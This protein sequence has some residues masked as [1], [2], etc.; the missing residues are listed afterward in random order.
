M[1]M[2]LA[3]QIVRYVDDHQPGWVE[4]QFVDAKGQCHTFRDKVPGFTAE[5]LGPESAYP[6]PGQVRCEALSQSQD[7]LE[8]TLIHISTARP[9]DIESTEGLSEFEV[10]S[11][12]LSA[13]P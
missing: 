1:K 10:L 13:I 5:H 12:Q 9:D 7:A 6:Q 4:S 3:V 8:R 11:E 2:N